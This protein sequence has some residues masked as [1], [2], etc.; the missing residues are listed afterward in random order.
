MATRTSKRFFFFSYLK[1]SK[2]VCDKFINGEIVIALLKPNLLPRRESKAVQKEY[3]LDTGANP[4]CSEFEQV[5][6][7]MTNFKLYISAGDMSPHRSNAQ[8][9]PDECCTTED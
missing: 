7:T 2:L 4:P 9:K 8:G 3:G 1:L 6:E 5:T